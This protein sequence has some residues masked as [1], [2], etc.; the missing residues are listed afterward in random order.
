MARLHLKFRNFRP[1]I[2]AAATTLFDQKPWTVE[3]D[4][5]WL[6]I[7]QA[8]T[9]QVSNAY[10]VRSAAVD[11]ES[12]YRRRTR[13]RYEP[14]QMEHSSMSE[15]EELVEVSPPRIVLTGHSIIVLFKG[16]RT[17][18]LAQGDMEAVSHDDPWGWACSL[19]YVVKPAMFRARARERRIKGVTAKDTYSS[20]TWQRM[21]EAGVTRGDWLAPDMENFDPRTLQEND[22]E[23]SDGFAASLGDDNE[24]DTET[25][26]PDLV[27]DEPSFQDPAALFTGDDEESDLPSVQDMNR[28]AI[29]G[30]AARH[31]VEGRGTMNRDD[32]AAV[33]V[34][35]GLARP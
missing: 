12:S 34:Q 11:L 21:T 6:K 26:D 5:Q 30:L 23:D 24:I 16:V 29:R 15:D 13:V 33:L 32:L 28:D 27:T 1:E 25:V 3:D 22:S 8:F 10:G 4:E 2:V 18:A 35:R 7:A 19:F 14:A 9:D 31:K 20:E 17:H